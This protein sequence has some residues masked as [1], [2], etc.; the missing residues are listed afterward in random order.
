MPKAI[1]DQVRQFI[2]D[3]FYTAAE[4]RL[5]DHA[6]LFEE[7]IIDSTGVLEIIGFLEEQF[8]ISVDESE[9]VPENLDSI[10]RIS[11]F[12]LR[13]IADDSRNG[14][15]QEFDRGAA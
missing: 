9:T 7:G 15:R 10:D 2:F 13:K 14:N 1:R 5:T 8:S 11:A 3:N 12:A 6:S 4:S